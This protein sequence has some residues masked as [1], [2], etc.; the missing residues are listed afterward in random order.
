VA[1]RA[2]TEFVAQL[3]DSAKI[4]RLDRS[5][6]PPPPVSVLPPSEPPVAEPLAPEPPAGEPSAPPKP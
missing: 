1:R 4:E 2:Q 6:T 5:A 3:R